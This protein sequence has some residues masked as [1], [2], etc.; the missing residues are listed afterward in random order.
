MN[1]ED[2]FVKQTKKQTNQPKKRE[3]EKSM[4][5][6]GRDEVECPK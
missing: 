5:F 1:N 6:G 2:I 4:R 3:R